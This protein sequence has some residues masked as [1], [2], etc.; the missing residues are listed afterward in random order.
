MKKY[1]LSKKVREDDGFTLIELML[2]VVVLGIL[3]GIAVPRMTGVQDRANRAVLESNANTIRNIMEMYHTFEGK[4]PELDD[5][6]D[7][8]SLNDAL[9][10]GDYSISDI[11]I[12]SADNEDDGG[13]T[14]VVGEDD[15]DY[16]D[17]T[18]DGLEKS[19]DEDDDED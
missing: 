16:I 8:D 7:R 18:Q 6:E 11:N 3:S 13:Y 2:V 4:Y 12:I 15:G 9:A 14:I 5:V 17:I 10:D 19:W 1:K